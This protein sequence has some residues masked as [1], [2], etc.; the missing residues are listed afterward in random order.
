MRRSR[1]ALLLFPCLW[2]GFATSAAAQAREDLGTLVD[3]K[4]S[5]TKA[6]KIKPP[7]VPMSRG[8]KIKFNE[9]PTQVETGQQSRADFSV[10]AEGAVKMGPESHFT[11]RN[12]RFDPETGLLTGQLDL[13][14]EFGKFWFWFWFKHSIPAKGSVEKPDLARGVVV[15]VQT[16]GRPVLLQGTGVFMSVER[17]G[18]TTVIVLEGKVEIE[19][20][21]KNPGVE[22]PV[23]VQSGFWTTFQPGQAAVEPMPFD[24]WAGERLGLAA[25]ELPT[26]PLLDLASPRLDLPKSIPP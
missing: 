18:L 13:E 10:G 20:G 24:P 8:D 6:P 22:K 15:V 14:I 5:V 11:F 17:D 2:I 25:P 1:L 19:A 26:P 9:L 12:G 16:P 21:R 3:G 7:P 23:T 4:G